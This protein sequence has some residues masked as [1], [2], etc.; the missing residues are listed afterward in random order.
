MSDQTTK[1]YITEISAIL[2]TGIAMISLM[3]VGFF[4]IQGQINEQIKRSDQINA[5]ADQ[6][7]ME[8][9][10]LVKEVHGVK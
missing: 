4:N 8:F 7:H 9:I 1:R 10:T 6:L 2:G 3:I 5:R